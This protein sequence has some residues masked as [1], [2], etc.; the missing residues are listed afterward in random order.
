M[1]RKGSI[2][3]V[4]II[5]ILFLFPSPGYSKKAWQDNLES[6]V[7]ELYDLTATNKMDYHNVIAPGTVFIL[8]VEGITAHPQDALNVIPNEISNGRVTQQKGFMSSLWKADQGNSRQFKVGDRFYLHR[9]QAK[10]KGIYFWL[11]TAE[12]RDVIERGSTRSARDSALILF[13]FPDD[14]LQNLD[15]ETI[16]AEVEKAL[17]PEDQVKL[18]APNT[19]AL[20]QT[21]EE[22]ESILGK[23]VTVL[24]LGEKVIYKY[25]DMKVT[26]VNGKV[27]DLE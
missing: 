1:I 14:D 10:E 24:D 9:V 26:F 11:I 15:A 27:T 22:V 20:G 12:T 21:R 18:K 13:P 4:T 6:I 23:P 19:L 17:V 25:D 5:S 16:K 7:E 3:V 8:Q 2:C